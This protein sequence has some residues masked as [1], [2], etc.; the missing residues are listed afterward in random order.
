MQTQYDIEVFFNTFKT[1]KKLDCFVFEAWHNFSLNSFKALPSCR[2]VAYG[3][4]WQKDGNTIIK[5]DK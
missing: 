2:F 1:N 4:E 3:I 5:L